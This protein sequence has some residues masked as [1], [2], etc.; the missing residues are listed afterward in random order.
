[1]NA[2]GFYSLLGKV[3]YVSSAYYNTTGLCVFSI[4]TGFSRPICLFFFRYWSFCCPVLAT[5]KQTT[6]L[7][8]VSGPLSPVPSTKKAPYTAR[9]GENI[10]G[11]TG[12]HLSRYGS[13]T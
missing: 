3:F 5:L 2:A 10:T 12:Q 7:A 9:Y 6:R 4:C 13:L 8:P 1:M 11:R